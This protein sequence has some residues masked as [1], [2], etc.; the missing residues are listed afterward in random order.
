MTENTIRVAIVKVMFGTIEGVSDANTEH[1]HLFE[2]IS[3]S[4]FCEEEQLD[5]IRYPR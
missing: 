5:C 2:Q 3:P 4:W 1:A